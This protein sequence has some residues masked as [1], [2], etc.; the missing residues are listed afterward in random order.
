MDRVDAMRVFVAIADAGG[1]AAAG[2]QLRMSPP[3][4]TRAVASLEASLGTR[5]LVRTTRTVRLT[6]PGTRYLEDCRRILAAIAEAEAAAAGAYAEP[7]GTL[8]V[9]ASV[10][11]GRLYVLPVLTEFLDRHPRVSA[12]AL[13]VDRVTHL[14]D[15]GL[16][17]AVRIAH[18]PD[19]SLTAIRVGAV[20]RVVVAAPAYLAAHGEPATPADLAGHRIVASFGASTPAAW[21]FGGPGAPTVT[22]LPRLA[23]STL[24]ATIDAALSGWGLARVLSY[25]VAGHLQDGSLRAVLTGWE[26]EPVPVHIVH[27]E[28]RST[29]AKVRAFVDLAVARLRA[30]RRLNPS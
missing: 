19:S 30:D 24:D 23:C 20:R 27:A 14:V 6:E 16:D 8:A 13:F 28:G 15:E 9:T 18:L 10:M 4:V 26:P 11:F 2:R 7:S 1:F 3:A 25:Q 29:S 12:R 17:V 5:L 22:V 21:S